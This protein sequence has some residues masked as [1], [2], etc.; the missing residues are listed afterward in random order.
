M[1]RRRSPL[2]GRVLAQPN[3]RSG[4][5]R[6]G[7]ITPVAQLGQPVLGSRPPWE[8]PREVHVNQKCL[9]RTSRQPELIFGAAAAH[10]GLIRDGWP[11]RGSNPRTR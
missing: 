3:A 11:P 7:L 8:P 4:L 2:N 10:C 1:S 6:S 5:G 9:P